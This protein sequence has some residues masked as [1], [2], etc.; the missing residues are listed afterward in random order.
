TGQADW[1]YNAIRN[2]GNQE[3]S[4]WRTLT[5]DEWT[6][7]LTGRNTASGIRFAMGSVNGVDGL[8][9]LPDNWDASTYTLNETND[10]YGGFNANTISATDW[11]TILEANGAVF[12]PKTVGRN[13]TSITNNC[14]YWSS[15]H[16]DINNA[17]CVYFG[18]NYVGFGNSVNN[19]S[20]GNV[21]RLVNPVNN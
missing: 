21:V 18:N 4:G 8:I 6:Y 17:Y 14:N 3:N 19:R 16:S 20:T 5:H 2:G 13:G 15:T 11:T 7:I 9:L 1:G 10:D 12:L